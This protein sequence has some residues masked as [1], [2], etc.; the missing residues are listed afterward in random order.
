MIEYE[1]AESA[2]K[3]IAT[4]SGSMLGSRPVV[5]RPDRG[6]DPAVFAEKNE[7]VSAPAFLLNAETPGAGSHQN[8]KRQILDAETPDS[9]ESH[10]PQTPNP[11]R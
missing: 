10:K 3:A 2:S 7:K 1:N 8:P 5:L 4:L 9:H 11:K 6:I